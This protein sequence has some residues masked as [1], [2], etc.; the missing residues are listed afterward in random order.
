ILK[1]SSTERELRLTFHG[2]SGSLCEML[3]EIKRPHSVSLDGREIQFKHKDGLL[4]LSFELT[5][6]MQNLV[7]I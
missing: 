6:K 5:G 7:I 2:G 1:A 3:L 4:K